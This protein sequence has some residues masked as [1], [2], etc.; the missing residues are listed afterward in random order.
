MDVTTT[1]SLLQ[2]YNIQVKR[3][4][5]TERGDL[6]DLFLAELNSQRVQS[7]FKP[8]SLPFLSRYFSERRMSVPQIYQFYMDCKRAK[9][10][11]S[12]FWF[13]TSAK[14]FTAE[15]LSTGFTTPYVAQ[16]IM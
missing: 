9:N 10:F 5:R 6:I 16:K 12:Y 1:K 4:R 14:N 2:G 11:S 8:L 15:G 13:M 7:G 3:T